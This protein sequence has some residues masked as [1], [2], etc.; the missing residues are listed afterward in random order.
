MQRRE[1]EE[2]L[3]ACR[4]LLDASGIPYRYEV[5]IGDGQ[6]ERSMAAISLSWAPM[7]GPGSSTSSWVRW[8]PTSSMAPR[9]R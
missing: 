9:Y 1:G 2:E 7:A 8:P 3:R 5:L 6:V 4:A